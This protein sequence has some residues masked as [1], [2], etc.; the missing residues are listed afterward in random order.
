MCFY[1]EIKFDTSIEIIYAVSL[2]KVKRY[3]HYRSLSLLVKLKPNI[4]L[5]L[6]AFISFCTSCLVLGLHLTQ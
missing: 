2:M 6:F 3:W 5:N 1:Y 4:T